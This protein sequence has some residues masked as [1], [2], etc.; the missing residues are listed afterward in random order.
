M[1]VSS[2]ST[3]GT[4]LYI[5]L[6]LYRNDYS[7]VVWIDFLRKK[8]DTR[9]VVLNCLRNPIPKFHILMLLFNLAQAL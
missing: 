4:V 5:E 7:T 2:N 1:N 6:M 9:Q 8:L 3:V